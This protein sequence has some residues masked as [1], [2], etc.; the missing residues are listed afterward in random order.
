LRGL[1]LLGR[2]EPALRPGP[3]CDPRKLALAT[4]LRKETTLTIK[5]I[6]ARLNLDTPRNATVRLQEWSRRTAA[7]RKPRA[8]IGI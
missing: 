6:A 1:K 7:E 5:S 3:K 8:P 2:T 4:R